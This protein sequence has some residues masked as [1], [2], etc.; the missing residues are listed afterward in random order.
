MAHLHQA[1]LKSLKNYYENQLNIQLQDLENRE[2]V[3]KEN[4]EKVH[5]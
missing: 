5:K 1:D 2:A 4:R 3:I